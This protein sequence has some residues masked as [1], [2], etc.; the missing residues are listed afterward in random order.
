[1]ILTRP[2]LALLVLTGAAARADE[3]VL[4]DPAGGS[5]RLVFLTAPLEGARATLTTTAA[6]ATLDTTPKRAELAGLTALPLL[7][8]D[9]GA[10]D[11]LDFEVQLVTES[12]ASSDDDKDGVG[13]RSGFSV[14]VLDRDRRGIELAFWPKRVWAQDDGRARKGR[15]LFTQAEGAEVDT[16]AKLARYT[17][18][19]GKDQYSLRRDGTV[20]LEGRLRDYSAFA[21]TPNPYRTKNYVF[22]GDNS[23]R[24]SATVRLGRVTLRRPAPSAPAP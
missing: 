18:K 3:L 8:P 17:V 20:L 4:F 2:A 23:S 13:D 12:H 6:P 15:R 9:V 24:S 19:L 14:I 11:E 16:T 22:L 10:G 1:M 5:P 7:L 21:G